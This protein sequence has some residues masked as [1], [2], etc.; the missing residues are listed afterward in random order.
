MEKKYRLVGGPSDGVEI[1]FGPNAIEVRRYL[2]L[3]GELYWR[4]GE[5]ADGFQTLKWEEDYAF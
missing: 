4:T 3:N 2:Y 5:V 1:T